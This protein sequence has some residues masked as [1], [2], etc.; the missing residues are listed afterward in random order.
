MYLP[1]AT[2]ETD[3]RLLWLYVRNETCNDTDIRPQVVLLYL[4]FIYYFINTVKVPAKYETARYPPVFLQF[5][6]YYHVRSISVP[7]LGAI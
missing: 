3:L 1:E 5:K 2:D 4:F 7:R 6:K